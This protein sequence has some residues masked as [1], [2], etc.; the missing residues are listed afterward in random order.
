VLRRSKFNRKLTDDGE[1]LLFEES[2]NR[3]ELEV[4]WHIRDNKMGVIVETYK[5]VASA[6]KPGAKRPR[7]KHALVDLASGKIDGLA[8]LNIDRLTRRKDQC[9]PILN[10]LEEMGGR[11]F[12]L[13]DELDTADDDPESNTELR[14]FQLVERAEREA[15]R[16]SERMKLVAR[17]R[18]RAG[19]VQRGGVRPFG[20]TMDWTETVP[21][22]VER[23]WEAVRRVLSG[24]GYWTV[25]KD[26]NNQGILTPQGKLWTHASLRYVLRSPRLIAK[27]RSNGS[28]LPYNDVPAILDEETWLKLQ[29]TLDGRSYQQG[30]RET[31]EASN[32]ALCGICDSPVVG[33]RATS[34]RT[35]YG[36]RKNSAR[37]NACGGVQADT[38]HMDDIIDEQ[39]VEFLNDNNRVAALLA[40][41]RVNGPEMDAIDARFAELQESKVA[42]EEARFNPPAGMRRLPSERYWELR[43]EIEQEQ[44]QLQ[45]RRIVN[46]EAEPLKAAAKKQWTVES[47]RAAPME[48]RRTILALVT[49]RIEI[50]RAPSIHRVG[51]YGSEFDPERVKVKFAS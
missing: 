42:L 49:E 38:R 7:Y 17:H 19:L 18:A 47:W 45:R 37:P 12:S 21:E 4:V 43:G 9:R 1:V 10:A 50:H 30:R 34:G 11:L 3:Q 39:V 5:D 48:W 25:A 23:I 20:H 14:L 41:H 51:L 6:W 28:L 32:I 26:W 2:T 27:Q 8:V 46:R 24:Q 15:R 13:E 29:A 35:Y 16:T 36:C 33:N 22:E 31:H 44:E 40:Q